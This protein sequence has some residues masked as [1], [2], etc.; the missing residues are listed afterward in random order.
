MHVNDRQRLLL[1]PLNTRVQLH[2]EKTIENVTY[3]VI[4][5]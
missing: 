3:A 4:T 2:L 1:L 5:H